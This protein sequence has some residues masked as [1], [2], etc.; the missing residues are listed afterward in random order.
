MSSSKAQPDSSEPRR[1]VQSS[2]VTTPM[3]VSTAQSRSRATWTFGALFIL[4][5]VG[6][7]ILSPSSLPLFKQRIVAVISALLA[8]LFAYFFTGDLGVNFSSS[9]NSPWRL[10][11]KG[12]GGLAAFALVLVWW[13]SPFS[14]LKSDDIVHLRVTVV[15]PRGAPIEN[16]RVWTSVGGEPKQV[17]GGWEFDIPMTKRPL[18]GKVTIYAAKESEFLEGSKEVEL[19][20]ASHQAISVRLA[21]DRSA[22]IRGTVVDESGQALAGARVSVMGFDGEAVTTGAG[23]EFVL[24]AHAADGQQVRLRINKQGY[25]LLEQF[26]MA[27]SFPARLRL[28][29]Q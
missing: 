6:F 13:F 4:F 23:G 9:K 15:G 17:A 12:T 5:L 29:R 27:G 2:P 16:S 7:F 3:D 26:Q 1:G 14:P 8:G 10:A 20:E 18:D 25:E 22:I 24:S 19:G 21:P 11:I 28:Q